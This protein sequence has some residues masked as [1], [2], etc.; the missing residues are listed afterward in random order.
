M[1]KKG[2]FRKCLS[3]HQLSADEAFHEELIHSEGDAIKEKITVGFCCM[4]K[5][6]DSKPMQN[7]IKSIKAYEDLDVICFCEDTIFNLEIEK[8]PIVE[9]FICFYSQG[10]PFEKTINYVKLRK[11]FQINDL[12]SQSIL[13]DRRKIY[14]LLNEF[15]IPVANHYIVDRKDQPEIT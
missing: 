3:T 14:N 12:E 1:K 13:W 15:K 9:V 6:M 7:I 5:K 10:F 4:G 2:A 11:P 8:W